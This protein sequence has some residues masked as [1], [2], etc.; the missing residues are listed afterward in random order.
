MLLS[1]IILEEFMDVYFTIIKSRK[2]LLKGFDHYIYIRNDIKF[3]Q[4]VNIIHTTL[5][6]N[7]L[8]KVKFWM[9]KTKPKN[10]SIIDLDTHSKLNDKFI[11]FLNLC[12]YFG[13]LSIHYCYH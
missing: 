7:D 3:F 12:E 1:S 6:E 10:I 5:N 13:V 11:Y 8:V 4:S 2:I 9:N